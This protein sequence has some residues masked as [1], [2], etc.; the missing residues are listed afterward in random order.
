MNTHPTHTQVGGWGL[1]PMIVN[2]GIGVFSLIVACGFWCVSDS[3]GVGGCVVVVF[4][5]KY[6]TYLETSGFIFTKII[7]ES[8]TL[9]SQDKIHVFYMDHTYQ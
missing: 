8:E 6:S 2:I 3:F 7:L 4:V 9:K 5:P 1:R